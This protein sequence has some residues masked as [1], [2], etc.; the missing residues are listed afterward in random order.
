MTVPVF[1]SYHGADILIARA[2]KSSLERL[3]SEFDVFL[4]KDSIEPSEDFDERIAREIKRAEWF[5]IVCTGFPRS[6]ADMMWS[7]YEAG[8]FRATLTGDLVKEA[9]KRIVCVFDREPPNILAKFQGVQVIGKQLSG[10][11]ID[12]TTTVAAKDN[13][14]YDDSAIFKLFGRMLDNVPKKPLRDK[15]AKSTQEMMREESLKLIKLFEAS[16]TALKIDEKS[17]QPRISFDL[18]P[19]E[20]LV[21][22]TVVT[23]YDG[24]LQLLFGID[25]EVAPWSRIVEIG[26][27]GSAGKP[28]WI[29]DIESAAVA[30]MNKSVPDNHSNK[31]VLRD[32]IYRVY[33]SRYEVFKSE[34]RTIYIVFLP[35]TNRHF[36]VTRSSSTLLSSL[37]LSVRFREQLVPMLEDFREKDSTKLAATLWDFYRRLVSIEIEAKQFGLSVEHSIPR[38]VAPLTSIFTKNEKRLL[39]QR[40]IDDWTQDR[41]IIDQMFVG[42]PG[43]L[44]DAQG[45]TS[46][47]KILAE[48]LRRVSPVN[49]DFIELIS[50]ELVVQIREG[51]IGPSSEKTKVKR[52]ASKK[53]VAGP[54]KVKKRKKVR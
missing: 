47:A 28:V 6:D 48:I 36:D 51:G 49:A 38:E 41:K 24:S 7:F 2:L 45:V 11:L 17:L 19:K 1:L 29:S 13:I 44:N 42:K 14:Q 32:S 16:G 53:N 3:T 31:C 40:S 50:E 4:D 30:I 33:A 27:E 22:D 46:S 25:A 8:Q 52:G 35:A 9:D 15:T 37:I 20:Q 43:A 10:A 18:L 39:I 23:G 21:S 5:L 12:T 54:K 26:S 34:K